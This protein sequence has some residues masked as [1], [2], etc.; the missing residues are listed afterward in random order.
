MRISDWS[1]DV[2]SSDLGYS[3]SF[4]QDNTYF[5]VD[6]AKTIKPGMSAEAVR[7]LLGHPSGEAIYPVSSTMGNRNMEYVFGETKGFKSQRNS[8][9]VEVGANGKVVTNSDERSG[10]KACV[11]TCRYRCSRSH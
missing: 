5:D 8:L 6:K 4:K 3:S 7:V 11:S 9:I 10:G 2:C 1:S